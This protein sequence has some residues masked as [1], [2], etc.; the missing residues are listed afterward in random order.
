MSVKST[1]GV[2]QLY[3]FISLYIHNQVSNDRL[4]TLF[5]FCCVCLYAYFN[6]NVIHFFL[7]YFVMN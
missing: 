3:C 1:L 7:V 2:C 5:N 6:F 4:H